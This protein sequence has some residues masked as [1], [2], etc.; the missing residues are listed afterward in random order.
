MTANL[1]DDFPT[2]ICH[3]GVSGAL[4]Y[5]NRA[6]LDFTGLPFQA[7]LGTG[8]AQN[9]H[10]DD[11]DGCLGAYERAV[12]ECKSFECEYRL[13]RW[14]GEYRWVLDIG[15]P[16][17]NSKHEYS[18]YVRVCYD[19]TDRKL[20]GDSL[21]NLSKRIT[22]R[23][24]G[25]QRQTRWGRREEIGPAL[26]ALLIHLAL[27]QSELPRD[28]NEVQQ[29]LKSAVDLVQVAVEALWE[30]HSD[31][32]CERPDISGL[33]MALMRYCDEA[34][35]QYNI[36][37]NYSGV[38]V[39]QV[40][41]SISMAMMRLLQEGLAGAHDYAQA[42][43]ISVAL[44]NTA[45]K[46]RLTIEDNGNGVNCPQITAANADLDLNTRLLDIQDRFKRLGGSV[47]TDFQAG[48]GGCLIGVLP[49]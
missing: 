31:T 45:R 30:P 9:V 12:A 42:T 11:R 20:S 34:T 22:A 13:R 38:E 37:I 44:N 21:R 43:R 10:P 33:N 48:R 24:A 28:S 7:Q 1:L 16:F 3:T 4:T 19:N 25:E 17:Y 6:W 5:C 8:W 29:H 46:L 47:E 2:P 32:D 18:G 49:V 14:D 27:M 36:P 39:S 41:S 35:D 15:R 40:N 23:P 26:T